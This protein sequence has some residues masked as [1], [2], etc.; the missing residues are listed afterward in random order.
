MLLEKMV[1]EFCGTAELKTQFTNRVVVCTA[2]GE[3]AEQLGLRFAKEKIFRN[4]AAVLRCGLHMTQ[5]T[6]ENAVNSDETAKKLLHELILKSSGADRSDV[7]SFARAVRNSERLKA[8]LGSS[9]AKAVT[10]EAN[11]FQDTLPPVAKTAASVMPSSA[12]Q[13]F[14]SPRWHRRGSTESPWGGDC[15]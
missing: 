7:G 9:I 5:R 4:Q 6:L 8:D 12:P 14:D 3:A 15:G 13:R 2:D 10:E 1:D 11:L